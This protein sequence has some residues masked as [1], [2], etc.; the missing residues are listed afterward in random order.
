MLLMRRST[1]QRKGERNRKRSGKVAGEILKTQY[2]SVDKDILK[3]LN[4]L[5]TRREKDW[6][7]CDGSGLNDVLACLC[8]PLSGPVY[9]WQKLRN[10]SVFLAFVYT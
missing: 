4:R 10:F 6:V 7:N 9:T 8:F 2:D 3:W 5:Q 1:V